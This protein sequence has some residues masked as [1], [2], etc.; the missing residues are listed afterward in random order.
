MDLEVAS[1][2][3]PDDL[4][5]HIAHLMYFEDDSVSYSAKDFR[6]IPCRQVIFLVIEVLLLYVVLLK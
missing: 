3:I 5:M 6:W 1:E 2:L 4:L